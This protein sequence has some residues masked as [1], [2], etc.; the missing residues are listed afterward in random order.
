MT[1]LKLPNNQLKFVG[2]ISS[3]T[4]NVAWNQ[5]NVLGTYMDSISTQLLDQN[6]VQCSLVLK[7]YRPKFFLKISIDLMSVIISA[8]IL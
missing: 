1:S 7:I 5:I 8:I 4:V 6:M 3:S 2:C